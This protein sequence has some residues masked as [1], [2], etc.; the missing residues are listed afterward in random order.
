M[1]TRRFDAAVKKLYEAFHNNTLNPDDCKHCAVGNILDCSDSWKHLT[2]R[3]GSVKLNYVGL[4]N[5]NFGRRFN[6]YTP[7]ELLQIEQAFLKGC[8]YTGLNRGRLIRP[9]DISNKDILF[10][11]LSQ[12]VE[13]LCQLDCIKNFMDCSSLFNF[14]QKQE[15]VEVK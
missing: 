15:L 1:T 12:V 14:K 4:V 8:G 9:D 11:G 6:G 10:N 5:E 3:H 13:C 2:D 7:T